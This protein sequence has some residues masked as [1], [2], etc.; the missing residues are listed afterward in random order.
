MPIVTCSTCG[1]D[2]HWQWEEA[3]DKFG[4]NDGDG[5]VETDTVIAVLADAGYVAEAH[6]WGWHNIVIHSIKDGNGRELIPDTTTIGY[7]DPRGYLPRAIIDILDQA[8]PGG[9]A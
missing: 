8:L 2:Y 3:F 4:F 9:E 5:Q 7:D 6:P 1:S